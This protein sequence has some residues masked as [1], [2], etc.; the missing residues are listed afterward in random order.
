MIDNKK[1]AIMQWTL[2]EIKE[3]SPILEQILADLQ[4]L[5]GNKL[6]V[7][8]SAAGQIPYIL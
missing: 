2:S 3:V 4:P 7:L 5:E 6:L 8:S 1:N